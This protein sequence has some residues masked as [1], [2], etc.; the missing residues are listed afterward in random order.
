MKCASEKNWFLLYAEKVPERKELNTNA[1]K[2]L[3][4]KLS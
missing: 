4:N 1:A 3:L 2:E